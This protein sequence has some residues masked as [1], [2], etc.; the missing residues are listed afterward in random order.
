MGLKDKV[1]RALALRWLRG[2]LKDLRGKDKETGMG[3]VLKFLD[4]WKLVIGVVALLGVKLWD[5]AHNGHAGDIVGAILSVLGWM[6]AA[7][8]STEIARAVPGLLVIWGLVHKLIKAQQQVK[9]GSSVAG[10]L[11]TEGYI[12]KYVSDAMQGKAVEKIDKVEFDDEK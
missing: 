8:Y 5:A 4:G 11:S 1:V 9:A 12:T 7:D 10:A 3:K 2:K 6:P